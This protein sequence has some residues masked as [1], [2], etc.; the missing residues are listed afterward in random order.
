M[1][2]SIL[3]FQSIYLIGVPSILSKSDVSLKCNVQPI[4]NKKNNKDSVHHLV[5]MILNNIDHYMVE[6]VTG[7]M[8]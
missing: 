6:S 5:M 3:N 7:A 4:K 1:T 2:N 8:K